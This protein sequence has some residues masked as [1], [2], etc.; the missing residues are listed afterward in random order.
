MR[1]R[2]STH[3]VYKTEYHIVWTPR[4]RRKLLKS[5]V[6]E[7]LEKMLI[8]LE[9]LDED[10]EVMRVNVQLDHVHLVV[11]IPPRVSVAGVVQFMKSRT[12]KQLKEK[13][14]FMQKAISGGAGIWSR[15][16]CVSTIGMDE[17]AILHYV[18]HQEKEDKGQLNLE[19][20]GR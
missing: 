3:A 2:K 8:N 11:V 16:N 6:K 19:L 7:Y 17:K 5:G 13:F 4:Y 12:S 9:D 10:I 20:G 1:F 15:G 14:E 18:E